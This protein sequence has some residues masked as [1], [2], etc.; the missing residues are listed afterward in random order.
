MPLKVLEK[1]L[2]FLFK[3]GYEPYGYV[4]WITVL[5]NFVMRS[6]LKAFTHTQNAP[7]QFEENVN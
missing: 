1:S 3:K 6:L 7:V 2:N 5:V 4:T